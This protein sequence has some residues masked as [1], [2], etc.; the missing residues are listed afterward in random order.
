MTLDSIRNSCDVFTLSSFETKFVAVMK[1]GEQVLILESI[2]SFTLQRPAGFVN[3]RRAGQG[4]FFAG[5]GGASI[6]AHKK[7]MD[8]FF[9]P[10]FNSFR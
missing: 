9:M 4:P 6:P 1:K 2:G 7:L 5:W 8:I 10:L 3:F